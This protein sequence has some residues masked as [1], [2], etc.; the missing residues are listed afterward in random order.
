MVSLT[1][2]G[3]VDEIGGNK[4]LLQDGHT[5]IWLDFGMSFGQYRRFFE[6]YMS[7]RTKTGLKDFMTMNLVPRIEGLYSPDLLALAGME[8]MEPAFDGVLISHP[9]EDHVKYVSFLHPDIP[10]YMGETCLA[11]REKLEEI[12][13]STIDERICS[14]KERN[15]ETGRGDGKTV[16]RSI[17]IFKSG[18]KFS[19]GNI[20]IVPMAVDH[21]IPGA[22]GFLIYTSAGPIVYTGDLRLHG[23][24]GHLTQQFVQKAAK[25][26]PVALITEGTRVADVKKETENEQHV[27][28]TIL[29]QANQTQGLVIV[30][31]AFK[32]A[33]RFRTLVQVAHETGRKLIIGTKAAAL[34]DL[35]SK[36]D[37]IQTPPI[38]DENTLIH[39]KQKTTSHVWERRFIEMDNSTEAEDIG[40]NQDQF[41]L[42]LNQ[43]ALNELIDI[44]PGNALYVRSMSEPYNEEM[45]LDEG[46]VDNWIDFF[47]MQKIRA[48]CSG[49]APGTDLLDIAM[50]IKA[51][52]VFPIHTEHPEKFEG[53]PGDIIFVHVGK[54]YRI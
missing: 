19:V 44:Q 42:G 52:T 48:H 7:P 25:N 1:F 39:I 49:H 43:W 18:E 37:E 5:K 6:E 21:S 36:I 15:P 29:Q 4:V 11:V 2:Y 41:I 40:K 51:K 28:D 17:K 35:Y 34:Y 27:K 13:S 10:V 53:L 33:D 32:D 20:E 8:A 54:T 24:N 38:D 23:R 14:Y 45:A 46:R 50:Q 12:G 31:Y 16:Q 22:F 26:K 47:H 3:G 30:D 9:H